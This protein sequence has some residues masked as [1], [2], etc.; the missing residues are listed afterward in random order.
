MEDVVAVEVE[1]DDGQ[2]RYFLTWGRI[3]DRVEGGPVA[4]IVLRNSARFSLG[5]VPV[6]ARL[7]LHL[8]DAA[9]SDAAPYFYEAYLPFARKPIPYGDGYEVWR[10]QRAAAME[11]GDEIAFCGNP[12]QVPPDHSYPWVIAE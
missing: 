2:K 9:D 1:L 12:N 3:Q 7:C 8:R 6:R 10:R 11:R 4:E 5:A